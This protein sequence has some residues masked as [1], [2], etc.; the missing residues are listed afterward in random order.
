LKDGKPIP[1][2]MVVDKKLNFPKAKIAEGDMVILPS[3]Q[4]EQKKPPGIKTRL[5]SLNP[6]GIKTTP[7]IHPNLL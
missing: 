3:V 7:R 5:T 4:S 6:V 2:F 1:H